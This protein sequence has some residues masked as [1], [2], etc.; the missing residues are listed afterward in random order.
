[1]DADA[2]SHLIDILSTYY[3]IGELADYE[4]LQLGFVNV[5]YIIETVING[6]KHRYF[7]RQY[8]KGIKEEEIEFEHSVIKHLVNKCFDLVARVINTRDGKTYIKRLD[9]GGEPIFFAVFDFLPGDDKYTWVNPDCNEE[10]LKQ[11]AVVL[12]QYHNAVYDLIP[13]GKRYESK[14]IDLL[15]GIAQTAARCAQKAGTTAFDIFFL[16]NLQLILEAIERRISAIDKKESE[17]LLHLVIHCDY[18]PGN[19]KFQNGAIIGLFDFDWSKL[20]ARCFDVAHALMYFCTAWE[21]ENDGNLQL[22]K[23]ATFLN[24]YQNTLEDS[25]GLDP[26]NGVELETL[27]HMISASILYVLNWTISDFYAKEADPLVYLVYLRHGV[28]SINWFEKSY[29]WIKLQ[30]TIMELA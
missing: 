21:G 22:N 5:S 19:L 11:S 14:I 15:P 16:E 20:D 1:M 17:A 8:K 18:H 2:T 27:P 9:S 30:Q 12:A 10:T 6:E 4:Q 3:N 26:M 28:R 29:N 7:L 13:E 23:V 25:G 24:A